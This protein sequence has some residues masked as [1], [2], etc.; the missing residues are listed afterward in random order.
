MI[1]LELH[2]HLDGRINLVA[3]YKA[4]CAERGLIPREIS[5]RYLDQ[6]Q[7]VFPIGSRQASAVALATAIFLEDLG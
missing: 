5:V 2:R 6:I 3:A 1:N 7:E 4:A